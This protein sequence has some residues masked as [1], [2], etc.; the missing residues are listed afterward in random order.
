MQWVYRLQQRL[1]ITRGE[2][3][4]ILVL[5]FLFA[6]GLAARYLQSEAQPLPSANYAEAE[7]LFQHASEAPLAEA[8]AEAAPDSVA[9]ATADTAPQPRVYTPKST[10]PAASVNLNT[11]TATELQRLPRIGPKMAARIIAYREAHGAFRRVQ[12]LVQ[13]R[14]IGKKTL[15]QLTPYLIV[16]AEEEF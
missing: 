15:A 7:R 3:N 11:A 4:V 2:C 14:G 9:E 8:A 10:P 12:D 16:D 5:A 13:V 1:A 6:L